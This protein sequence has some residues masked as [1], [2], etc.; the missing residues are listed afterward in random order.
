MAT[1]LYDGKAIIPAPLVTI[2]KIYDKTPDLEIVGKRY[3][4]TLNGTLVAFKG[5]PRSDGTFHILSGYPADENIPAN[6]R[7]KSLLAKQ[8]ALQDLF[9]RE[10]LQF[11]IQPLDGSQPTKCNPRVNS[12]TFD[13]GI[14]YDRTDYTIVLEADDLYLSD[15]E[16]ED[17]PYYIQTAGESWQIE[18]SEDLADENNPL[19]FRVTHTVNA[20]GK[21][22]YNDDGT[23][24]RQAW[25]EASRYC[26]DRSGIDS[27]I[28]YGSGSQI[29]GYF[30]A[31]NYIKNTNLDENA[32]TYSLT[33][34]WIFH[35]GNAIET[36]DVQTE[37]TTDSNLN[38]VNINGNIT[39][40]DDG[41]NTKYEN[42]LSKFNVAEGL[43]FTRCQNF[44]GLSLNTIPRSKTVGKNPITGTINY[45]YQ[46]DDS[47]SNIVP[48]TLFEVININDSLEG[49]AFAQI[50]VLGRSNGPVLQDLGSITE[51]KRSLNIELILDKKVSFGSATVQ[52]IQNAFFAENPRLS[53][54]TSGEISNIIEA[55]NPK[56][57]GF[58]TVF[59]SP[60]VES[61]EPKNGRYSYSVEWVYNKDK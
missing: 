26:L 45:A 4:I 8:K 52:D 55:A 59:K 13:S 16:D 47:P 25:E 51:L 40:L 23:L 38:I 57:H 5:S 22:F 20:T 58:T 9:S 50:F 44:S 46:Y 7:L 29:P 11:E 41:I 3:T 49:D 48:N 53:P 54:E 61:W 60:P 35:S 14:W 30:N 37:R 28:I 39:G 24:N 18:S 43:I 21:R 17:F 31:Y 34:T 56:N 36:F 19:G 32:G 15:D 6:E 42:A 10:G 27:N 1:I 12:I 2:N 33:E